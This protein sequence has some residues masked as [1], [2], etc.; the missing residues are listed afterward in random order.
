M[1]KNIFILVVLCV[2]LINSPALASDIRLI[3]DGNDVTSLATPIIKDGRTLLPIRF[4]SEE[5]GG[6]VDWDTDTKMVEVVK[7][8]KKILLK[9]ASRLTKYSDGGDKYFLSDV[10]PII[11]EGRTYIPL[12]LASS[13]LGIGL[14]WNDKNRTVEIDTKKTSIF[15]PTYGDE[16]VN[17]NNGQ[18]VNGSINLNTKISTETSKLGTEIKYLLL[19]PISYEGRIVARGTS[20]NGVYTYIPHFKDQGDRVLVAAIYDKNGKL[21]GGDGR[22]IKVDLKPQISLKGIKE[23]TDTNLSIELGL[24]FVPTY[25]KYEITNLDKGKSITSSEIDPWGIYTYSPQVEDN[26]NIQIRV[27]AYDDNNKVCASQTANT[28]VN[29]GRY[30]GLSGVKDNATVEKPITLNATRNFNVSE[31]EYVLRNPQTGQEEVLV[32]FGYGSYKWFPGPDYKGNR[33]VFARV[34]DTSGNIHES[35]RIP[36]VLQGKPMLILEGIGPNQVI[37]S[38]VD[39][40]TLA[41]FSIDNVEYV[42]T[43]PSKGTSKLLTTK[44]PSVEYKYTP[45]NEDKSYTHI[46]AV[47]SY[48]GQRIESESIPIKIYLD[49]TYGPK[50]IVE[51]DKFLGLASGLA[52][53]S[54]RLTSM[55]ASLQ[56]AQAILETGWGQSVPVDK[57]TGKFSYNLFGIKGSAT[58]GSV[59]S[60]TWEEYNGTVF[61]IDAE[62]RAYNNINESWDNH[63][64]LLLKAERYGIFRDVMYDS[65]MGAWAIRRAGYATDSQYPIKLMK[66]IKDYDLEKLDIVGI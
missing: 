39:I 31:T 1:R 56:T 7:G 52:I 10:A 55:S 57:Y 62:F 5:I 54:Y 3:M 4:I 63:K 49:K 38:T 59:V 28:L 53:D 50:A 33:E 66:I 51:K 64:E 35:K 21:I 2:F 19:D 13:V 30:L 37:T 6:K 45:I 36:I 15:N 25:V 46:K 47:G 22:L 61:R 34:K 11:V 40:K 32:K 20:L 9:I 17:I 18:V 29:V 26:G 8:K 48:N 27:I 12:R 43:N 14:E 16:I 44:N 23:T 60:N 24:N 65:T 58:N 42:L 41:N